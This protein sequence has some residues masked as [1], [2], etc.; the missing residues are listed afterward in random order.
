MLDR[1]AE[2]VKQFLIPGSL[3]F[4][5]LGLVLGVV[6][7]FLAGRAG[8]WGRWW[9]AFLAAGYL[10]LSLPVTAALLEG[11]LSA[12]TD[13]MPRSEFR[14]NVK[15]IVI[16]GG[17]SVT[18]R[19]G[20]LEISELSDATSLR[21]LEG[22][23]LYGL[24][25]QPMVIVSGGADARNGASSP[26]TDGMIQEL[27]DAGINANRLRVEPQSGST[28]EQAINLSALLAD[29]QVERFIL[30]TSPTHMRRS[31]AVFEAEGLTPLP[32]AAAQHPEGHAVL[33]GGWIPHPDALSASHSALREIM[34]VGYYWL[35]GWLSGN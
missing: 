3:A 28:R 9:L 7:L 1:I 22:A 30:I 12:D 17:G 32:S 24:L 4:L 15:T 25:D 2:F 20:D 34:A 11:W 35:R 8:T 31:L 5:L 16:L 29:L 6:L 14:E 26:E 10:V 33:R 19:S 27:I 13:S 21:V 18:F 23:R